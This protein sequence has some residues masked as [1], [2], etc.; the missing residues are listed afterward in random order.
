MNEI[1]FL[2]II[3]QDQAGAV[4][5]DIFKEMA[6]P[7]TDQFFCV[8]ITLQRIEQPI[9]DIALGDDPTDMVIIIQDGEPSKLSFIEGP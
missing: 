1:T 8:I 4:G 6:R 9:A 3:A 7:V 5:D 2:D